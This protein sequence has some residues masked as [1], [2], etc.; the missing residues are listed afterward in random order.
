MIHLLD[1]NILIALGDANHP[2]RAEA[3]RFFTTEAVV[4]GWATCPLTENAFLRILGACGNPL[5][6]GSTNAARRSLKTITG[7][8]GHH[9]WPDDFSLADTS[10]V[11]ELPNSHGLTDI[12]LLAL[13]VK[14][15]GRLVTFD[16]NIHSAFVPGGAAALRILV[17]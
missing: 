14:H 12:Y 8:P 5:G 15:G 3:L 16:Q 2:H 1:V 10:L 17:P 6:F 7:A 11:P 13:A 9:F 4:D